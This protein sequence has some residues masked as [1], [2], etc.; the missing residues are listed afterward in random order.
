MLKVIFSYNNDDVITGYGIAGC[1]HSTEKTGEVEIDEEAFGALS[2]YPPMFLRYDRIRK[3][4]AYDSIL[5]QIYQLQQ[6]EIK[7][8]KEEMVEEQAL[9]AQVE[10][11]E[12]KLSN[13]EDLIESLFQLLEQS[14]N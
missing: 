4:I 1:Y 9:R 12:N 8:A 11:L 7:T 14:R 13:L 2:N 10:T 3:T 6:T 5:Q